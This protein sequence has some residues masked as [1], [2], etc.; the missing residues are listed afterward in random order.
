MTEL[1]DYRPFPNEEGR[2]HRQEDWELPAMVKALDLGSRRR[3]LEIGCGR[4]VALPPLSRLCRPETLVGIDID[5]ELLE[6]A[7]S[8]LEETGV[9]ASVVHGDARSLPFEDG[10][11]DLVIDFGTL[12]HIGNPAQGLEEV[13]RVL[14]SG[15]LFAHET[16]LSQVLS[17]PVRSR[18]RSVPWSAVEE[19]RLRRWTPLWATRQRTSSPPDSR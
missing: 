11:F 19:L 10:S 18:G 3:I 15:G 12:Y 17:H 13:A 2:N 5:A 8:R 16:R 9:E 7:Q 1:L 6:V 14:D 4:G